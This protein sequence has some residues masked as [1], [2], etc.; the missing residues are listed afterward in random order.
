MSQRLTQ[1]RF[2]FLFERRKAKNRQEERASGISPD[3][4]YIDKLI[5][6]LIQL[7]QTANRERENLMKQ[8]TDKTA[9]DAAKGLEMR[10]M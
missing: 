6:E 7:F 1:E 3:V 10:S 5:D 9:L 4:S 8:K 2:Q